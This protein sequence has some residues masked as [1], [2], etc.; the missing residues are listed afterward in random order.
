MNLSSWYQP[1]LV[2]NSVIYTL[3]FR[4]F[5]SD[6]FYSSGNKWEINSFYWLTSWYQPV[7]GTHH[8]WYS[9]QLV[10]MLGL[11][12]CQSDAVC[13]SGNMLGNLFILTLSNWYQPDS[14]WY[15]PCLVLTAVKYHWGWCPASSDRT[16]AKYSRYKSFL[17]WLALLWLLLIISDINNFEN[18]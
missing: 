4:S 15:P 7:V 9:P 8:G 16:L 11:R 12:S 1:W 2:L 14:G 18:G 17:K 13:S 3:I 6:S 10:Q 5:Q